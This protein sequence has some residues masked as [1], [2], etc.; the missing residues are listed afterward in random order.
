MKALITGGAGFLGLRLAR[1]LLEQADLDGLIVADQT[2]TTAFA[3]N[4][5]VEALACDISDPVQTRQLVRSGPALIF[6]LAAVVSGEAEADFDLGMRVNLDGT[7]AL[8]EACRSL[9]SPPGLVFA[10]SLAVFGGPLPAAVT[11]QTAPQPRSSYGA[12]KAI[13]E[14]LVCEYSRRGFI[15]GRV[16]RLPTISVRP[17]APNRA[18]S[19]FVSGIIR[20]P[21]RGQAAV[22]PV[23]P[24]LRLWLSSP[25]MAVENLFRAGRIPAA[26]LGAQRILH[27]PG[28]SVT[29]REMMD[30]LRRAAGPEVCGRVAFERDE[31][32]ENIVG[33][34]P[35]RLD[36]SRARALGFSADPDFESVIRQFQR[37]HA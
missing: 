12:E 8:L 21:L 3:G 30:A 22:C 9:R 17:G 35:G 11:E 16:V 31:K 28:L 2:A 1:R 7:R 10:S 24:E 33:S 6:H 14:L 18:A 34:W 15:D 26:A 23:S 25:A 5:R 32:I 4:P 20:E 19:S 27:A 29:V 13:G 36:D 37:E